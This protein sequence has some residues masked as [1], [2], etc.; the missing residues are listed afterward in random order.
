[1]VELNLSSLGIAASARYDNMLYID[2]YAELQA[3][4][5]CHEPRLFILRV[6]LGDSWASV[7]PRLTAE[8]L[9]LLLYRVQG[10][11]IIDSRGNPTVEVDLFTSCGGKF[12][13]SVPSGASTG[14]HEVGILCVCL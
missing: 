3:P 2:Q 5:T 9:C 13:A 14:I 6:T 12:T 8:C 4:G 11:Q 10:R 7:F 1:M